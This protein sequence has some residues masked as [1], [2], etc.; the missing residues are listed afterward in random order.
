[1]AR[2]WACWRPPNARPASGDIVLSFLH[3]A[4]EAALAGVELINAREA[5]STVR[6]RAR[7][8]YLSISARIGA[9]RGSDGKTLREATGQPDAPISPWWY[10]PSSFRDCE[11]DP[12][13]SWIIAALTIQHTQRQ[14]NCQEL[15]LCGAPEE[16]WLAFQRA[17][18]AERLRAR[19]KPAVWWARALASRLRLA[20]FTLRDIARCRRVALWPGRLDVLFVGFWDWSVTPQPSGAL[21]DRYVKALPDRLAAQGLKSGWLCWLDPDGDPS[22]AGRPIKTVLAPLAGRDDVILLQSLLGPGDVAVE[23]LDRRPL[24]AYLRRRGDPAF[25]KIFRQE[26]LDLFPLFEERLLRGFLDGCLPRCGLARRA[27]ERAGARWAP[28][29]LFSFLEHN[30]YAKAVVTGLRRG[31]PGSS[32]LAMQ[33]ASLCAE[34]TFFFLDPALDFRGEPDGKAAPCPDFLF[35]M[36]SLAREHLR[37]CGYPEERLP[38][39]GSARFD[40]VREPAPV[41]PR[42]SARPLKVLAVST[43]DTSADIDM[44]EALCGASAGRNDIELCVRDHPFSRIADAPRFAPLAGKIAV[45]SRTLR[46]DLDWADLVLY[47]YSTV[48][49]EAFVEGKPVWQWLPLGY[50]ASALAE[51]AGIPQFGDIPRLAEALSEFARNPAPWTPDLE[52]RRQVCERLFFK[53]DGGSALRIAE[54]IAAALSAR[55]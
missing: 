48:A 10:H 42:P 55:Q 3:P 16:I 19:A 34:K 50:N 26:G 9:E 12:A 37:S 7:Q 6:A 5:S 4:D 2:L 14:R 45:S 43:L 54:A 13:F 40:H 15:V 39:T 25:R 28:K 8:L 30:P 51:A 44:V 46:Q 23:V 11:A 27:A 18:A 52:K 35:V 31:A 47:T 41:P 21:A 17:P 1:M 33:H 20:L 53:A 36:G 29:A 49:E 32:C 22:T 38:L 24:A